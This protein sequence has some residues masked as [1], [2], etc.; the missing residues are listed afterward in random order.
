MHI[1]HGLEVIEEN[2]IYYNIII[3]IYICIQYII[4]SICI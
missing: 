4:Y 3:H 1:W 2:D